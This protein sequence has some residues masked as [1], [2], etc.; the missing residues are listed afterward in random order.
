LGTL[1]N[2]LGLIRW[3]GKLKRIEKL[4]GKHEGESCYIVGKGVSLK[5]ISKDHFKDGFIITLNQA[6]D[7][8]EPLELDNTVYSMQKDHIVSPDTKYPIFI[9]SHESLD[10]VGDLENEFYVFTNHKIGLRS[11]FPSI[12]TSI[13]LAKLFG[14]NDI[15]LISFD[16]ITNGIIENAMGKSWRDYEDHGRMAGQLLNG[17]K[18][19]TPKEK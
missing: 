8:V 4:Y 5:Y 10:E 1:V 13:T 14:S 9:H 19:I 15:T 6:V 2:G 16:A 7:W 12:C 18:W 3:R 11:T 17:V